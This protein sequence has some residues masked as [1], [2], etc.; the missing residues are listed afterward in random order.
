MPD[1]F[2]VVIVIAVALIFDFINGFHDSANSIATVVATGVLTPLGAV[3][4]AAFFNFIGAF[5]FTVAVA[6]TIGKGVIAPSVV[7]LHVILAALAGGI[8]W[9]LF[10]WKLGLPSSSS[11]A[12]VGGLTGAALAAGGFAAV[13]ANGLVTIATFIVLAPFLGMVGAI[14]FALVIMHLFARSMPKKMN[15]Y[16]NM[17]MTN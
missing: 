10:T 7:N 8:V 13:Q 6:T 16:F 14:I 12:L 17:P 4:I 15:F 3:A 2:L 9:N 5:V 1:V 11:H